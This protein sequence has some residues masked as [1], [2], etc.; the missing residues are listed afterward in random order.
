MFLVLQQMLKEFSFDFVINSFCFY[1]FVLLQLFNL[2]FK[3]SKMHFFLPTLLNFISCMF[4]FHFLLY[5]LGFMKTII[6]PKT[7]NSMSII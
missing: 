2:R 7:I 6:M 3:T 5:F 1:R 4:E